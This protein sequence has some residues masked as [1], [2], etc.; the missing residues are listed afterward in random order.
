[1][2]TASTLL[3]K[4]LRRALFPLLR[5]QGFQTIATPTSYRWR[6]EVVWSL[7]VRAVSAAFARQTGWPSAS[8]RASVGVWYAFAVADKS[9]IAKDAAGNLRPPHDAAHV[10]RI[11]QKRLDQSRLTSALE[12]PAERGR[13]DVWWVVPDG[14]NVEEVVASL[15]DAVR[16]EGIP[17]LQSSGDLPAVY[18]AKRRAFPPTAEALGAYVDGA[19]VAGAAWQLEDLLAHARKVGATEDGDAYAGLLRSLQHG[20]DDR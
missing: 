10:R 20:T 3:G 8:I 4:S 16:A 7:C 13:T 17:F 9:R 6:D 18:Q 15:C 12:N 19:S 11:F 5:D 1:V 2:S 14:S